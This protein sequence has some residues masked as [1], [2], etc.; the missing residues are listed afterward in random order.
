MPEDEKF[1]GD[2]FLLPGPDMGAAAAGT[3]VCKGGVNNIVTS[4]DI[5]REEGD[6]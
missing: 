1:C 5:H 6:N 4:S 3:G 2:S